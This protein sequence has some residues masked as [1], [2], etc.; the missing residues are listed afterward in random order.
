MSLSP[1][2]LPS[3]SI[4]VILCIFAKA[5]SLALTPRYPSVNIG[6]REQPQRAAA[7]GEIRYGVHDSEP[8]KE[9]ERYTELQRQNSLDV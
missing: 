1:S 6:S 3:P 9:G 5:N 2:L 4:E 8:H 7:C